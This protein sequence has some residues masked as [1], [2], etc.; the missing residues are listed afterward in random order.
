[1]CKNIDAD[2]TVREHPRKYFLSDEAIFYLHRLVNK[3]NVRYWSEDDPRA[4]IERVTNSPQ[5]NVWC[6]RS[7]TQLIGPFFFEDD[8][9]IICQY[10]RTSFFKK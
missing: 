1:M 8:I 7:E 2:V 5:L 3:H 9:V 10:S 6:A 4:T